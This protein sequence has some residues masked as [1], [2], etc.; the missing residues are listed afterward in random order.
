MKIILK[1]AYEKLGN[2]G[3]AVSV[4]DGFARNYLIPKG[5]AEV[6]TKK[7][8]ERLKVEL[9]QIAIQDA[10]NRS[11]LESLAKQLNKLTLKFELQAG[12][13]GKLF[14]SVTSQMIADAIAEKGFDVA[15]K[16]IEI[17]EAIKTDGSHFV[18]VKLDKGFTGKIKIKVKGI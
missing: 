9:E 15:K 13:E 1:Q 11:S 5:I 8:I 10:K 14:G 2:A 4:K 18:E 6:A 17:P 7:N 16:E 12:E 3:E